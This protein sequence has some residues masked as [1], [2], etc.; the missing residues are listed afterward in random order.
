MNAEKQYLCMKCDTVWETRTAAQACCAPL[1]RTVFV[2]GECGTMFNREANAEECGK[3]AGHN[4]PAPAG[5]IRRKLWK[6][7]VLV[8]A[9]N[10]LI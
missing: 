5:Q 6:C 7:P 4:R 3:L 9:A 2:C 10:G 1:V 8:N